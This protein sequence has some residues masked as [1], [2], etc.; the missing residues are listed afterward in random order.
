MEATQF[1]AGTLVAHTK[2]PRSSVAQNYIAARIRPDPKRWTRD[3][4]VLG[5][6]V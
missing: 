4:Q 3:V 6:E 1:E 2:F 5:W